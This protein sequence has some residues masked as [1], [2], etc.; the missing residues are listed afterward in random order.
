MTINRKTLLPLMMVLLIVAGISSTALVASAQDTGT[1]QDSAVCG[2][3]DTDD[4]Q[5]EVESE[6]EDDDANEAQCPEDSAEDADSTDCTVVDANNVSGEAE[7]ASEADETDDADEVEDNDCIDDTVQ[8]PSYTGSIMVDDTVSY[9]SEDDEIT[10]LAPLVMITAQE[11]Q[12]T[13]ETETD[14]TVVK[15]ELDNENGVLVYS[16]ELEDGSDVKVD[17]GDGTILHTEA[18]GAD[19]NE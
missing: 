10:A 15:V 17:A 3:E 9:A 11:A 5:E 1:A 6:N 18:A 19:T 2:A 12:A 14:G 13:V 4:V 16:V 7:D 8:E